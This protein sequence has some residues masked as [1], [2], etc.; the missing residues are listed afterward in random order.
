MARGERLVYLPLGGAGEIGMNMYLYG[1]GRDG[2]ER[3]IAVDVGVTFPK[4]ESSPGVD[5]IMA[6]PEFVA[7]RAERLEAIFITHAH[8]DHVGA[9]GTLYPKLRAPVYA[10]RFTARIARDKMERA[11]QDV[12]RVRE[13]AA[14]PAQTDAGPFSVGFLPVSHSIPEASALVIDTPAGR[15]VHTGD[16]K[17]DPTPLV[18]EPFRAGAFREVAEP[19]VRVLVCDST[20]IFSHHL[21]RSEAT[22]ISEIADLVKSAKGMVVA[23]TFASNVARVRTL[24]EAGR[25]AG[26]SV[27]M[28]G[29]AMNAMKAH[30]EAAGVLDGFPAL[31]D[32]EEAMDM[33]RG[34]LMVLATGSQGERRGASAF[35]AGD[36]YRG[37]ELRPGDLFL[38]SSKTIPGNEI[39]VARIHNQL[40]EQGVRVVDGEDGR[41]HVSGH[42][43]RPDLTEVHELLQ[44]GMVIP[45]HGE[46]RH[47]SEHAAL[48]QANGFASVVAPNGTLVDLSGPEPEIAGNIETGRLYLDGTRLIGAM[49]GVV[50]ERLRMAMRGHVTISVVLEE[51]GTP[52]E[53]TWAEVRGLAEAGEIEGGVSGALERAIDS[54]LAKTTRKV[55]ASDKAVE[56]LVLRGCNRVCKDLLGKKPVTTVLI[57]RLEP[58]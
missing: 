56:E 14:W 11:G 55:L 40:S 42:A 49:D 46:H 44:P 29:R 12:T 52:A 1:Y 37:L 53:G 36:G 13:V 41:Y 45:M 38:F 23:T 39:P 54:D 51:D 33:A 47:L 20:N 7:E 48:A 28:I 21:G 5:L 27:V 50:R 30:A 17:L 15:I 4:M 10:R 32:L 16:L 3:W 57:N 35:L 25:A 58:E 6:D 18:G 22:L 43:N 26:R 24:A 34:D 8:E 9:L 31:V 2:A 19:G